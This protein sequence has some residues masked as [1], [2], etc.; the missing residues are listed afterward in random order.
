MKKDFIKDY[1]AIN[2]H[3]RVRLVVGALAREDRVDL[4]RLVN[5]CRADRSQFIRLLDAA[6]QCTMVLVPTICDMQS[7]WKTFSAMMQLGATGDQID[8]FYD[9]YRHSP[10]L[11]ENV[12]RIV[13]KLVDLGAE[14]PGETGGPG[15]SSRSEWQGR[16]KDIESDYRQHVASDMEDTYV[17]PDYE[18]PHHLFMDKVNC[19][20]VCYILEQVRAGLATRLGP[21]WLAFGSVCRS[22][23]GLEPETVLRAFAPPGAVSF[24]ED[25]RF[26]MDG[27]G[28][29]LDIDQELESSLRDLW[30]SST[31]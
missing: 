17:C 1:T 15:A 2:P 4:K 23:M 30:P 11:A 13:E 24:V 25:L 6:R 31:S 22:E 18:L 9:T 12:G 5:S 27:L 7:R 28:E 16:W 29:V 8:Y 21:A 3:G 14:Q 26:E 10:G 19:M 20:M